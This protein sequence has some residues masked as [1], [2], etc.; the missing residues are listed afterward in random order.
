MP[1][2]SLSSIHPYRIPLSEILHDP[3][4][5]YLPYLQYEMYMIYHQTVCMDTVAIFFLALIQKLIKSVTILV[6]E[7]K[8]LP[9]IT[10]KDDMVYHTRI[11]NARFSSHGTDRKS[12]V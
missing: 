7:K 4:K 6:L 12:A 11:M 5:C 8:I 1:C 10:P 9:S 3:G 2:P